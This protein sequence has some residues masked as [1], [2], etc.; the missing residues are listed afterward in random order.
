MSFVPSTLKY[1]LK[2]LKGI[3][4]NWFKV[5]PTSPTTANMG[6]MISVLL[7]QN[8]IIDLDTFAMYATLNVAAGCVPPKNVESLVFSTQVTCNG[9]VIQN[10]C[11]NTNILF[12]TLSDLTMGAKASNIRN[13]VALGNGVTAAPT[14]ATTASSVP[15][16]MSNFLGFLS[17]VSPRKLDSSIFGDLRLIVTLAG[18]EVLVAAG[19]TTPISWSLTNIYFGV[20][21]LSI[22]DGVYYSAINEK[23]KSGPI[24]TPF[25]Y[26]TNFTGGMGGSATLRSTLASE[27]INWALATCQSGAV[28]VGASN[29]LDTVTKNSQWF[30]R[31][32]SLISDSVM[33]VNNVFMPSYPAVAASGEIFMQTTD[34]LG[35]THNNYGFADANLTSLANFS[36]HYY[37]HVVKFCVDDD[38]GRSWKSGINTIGNSASINN[39]FTTSSTS[40]IPHLFLEA[41]GV[42]QIH[43]GR[44]LNLLY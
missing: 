9:Q 8:T 3:S 21:A 12:N 35:L 18:P 5:Y 39:K 43:A 41:T 36:G 33:Q 23:L 30:T 29:G 42:V 25:H 28:T 22:D 32:G 19:G 34:A 26:Y 2:E 13:V 37:A 6:A 11:Q 7:P 16:V 27:S 24:E 20:Q 40:N 31:D 15:I 38:D 14:N 10:P 4:L 17:S 44:Q 1:Y